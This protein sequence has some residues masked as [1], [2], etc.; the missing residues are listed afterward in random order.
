VMLG[1]ARDKPY[2]TTRELGR[3]GHPRIVTGLV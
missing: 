2:S 3:R 1:S